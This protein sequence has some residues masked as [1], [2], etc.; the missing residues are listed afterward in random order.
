MGY[1]SASV[2]LQ[3]SALKELAGPVIVYVTTKNYRHFAVFRG[4]R[5]DRIFLADPSRGNLIMPI[6]EFLKEWKG[7][8]FILG[9]KGFGTPTQ[10]PLA[11]LL[12]SR[13]RNEIE[14]L[15]N[16]ILKTSASATRMVLE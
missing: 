13:F 16:P 10:Y 11:V 12:S 7:E 9:K 8:T 15:R 6:D 1:Q 2:R 3:P 5:E 4:V 14:L